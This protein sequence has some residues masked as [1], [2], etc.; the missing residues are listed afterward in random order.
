MGPRAYWSE[1]PTMPYP[2]LQQP[3]QYNSN[4]VQGF[5]SGYPMG[6]YGPPPQQQYHDQM[7]SSL[8]P[9]PSS[10]DIHQQSNYHHHSQATTSSSSPSLSTA[11]SSYYQAGIPSSSGPTRGSASTS[12]TTA[13]ST[14]A[15]TLGP[16]R[17]DPYGSAAKAHHHPATH[18][19]YP[20]GGEPPSWNE[21]PGTANGGGVPTYSRL[22]PVDYSRI[23]LAA[24]GTG[25]GRPGNH[26]NGVAGS[27]S[28]AAGRGGP[29][30]DP[31]LVGPT[32]TAVAAPSSASSTSQHNR[33]EI[34]QNGS[35][36]SSSG[37]VNGVGGGV[38]VG[39]V[40]SK[41]E[42]GER[43]RPPHSSN[44]SPPSLS[45]RGEG[46]AATSDGERSGSVPP[47]H[48][49]ASRSRSR[50]RTPVATSSSKQSHS[51]GLPISSARDDA[52][53]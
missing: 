16:V 39:G 30:L 12:P 46:S 19:R 2:G 29:I 8:P 52:N 28:S 43:D 41:D 5:P 25:G 48:S 50:A 10:S 36:T 1:G 24:N 11:S 6:I 35:S 21:S 47:A 31:S 42:Q 53:A 13:A 40:N 4:Q 15:G 34:V 14:R 9:P 51:L 45:G 44:E 3:P 18:Q 7:S 20:S 32:I 37:N 33:P 23:H 38:G 22:P 27:S 26:P 49:Y 17:Y